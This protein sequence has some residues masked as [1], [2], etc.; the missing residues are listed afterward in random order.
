M[1]LY[2][3]KN[4]SSISLIPMHS[5]EMI[6]T[7]LCYE[8]NP[9]GITWEDNEELSL[10]LHDW[11]RGARNTDLIYKTEL[12]EN[13][14]H[15]YPKLCLREACPSALSHLPTRDFLSGNILFLSPFK[16]FSC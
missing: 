10:A 2:I 3:L 1:N 11:I 8:K 15:L 13:L 9:S 4:P 16:L 6:N 7:N 14:S 12:L 5:K